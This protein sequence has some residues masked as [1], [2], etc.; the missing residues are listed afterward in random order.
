MPSGKTNMKLVKQLLQPLLLVAALSAGPV[1]AQPVPNDALYQ[2]LGGQP[3]LVRLMDDFMARLLADPVWRGVDLP[4]GD[5]GPVLLIPG[6]LAGDQSLS[7]MASWLRKLGHT[8]KRAGISFNVACSDIAV[9]RL[10]QVL[11]HANLTSGRPVAVSPQ[12]AGRPL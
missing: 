4:R 3:G 6:F 10:S 2:Q 9:D 8:P 7:V 5:G 1:F 11:L 12:A